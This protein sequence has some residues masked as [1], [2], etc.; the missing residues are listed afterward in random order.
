MRSPYKSIATATAV[1]LQPTQNTARQPTCMKRKGRTL[2][3]SVFS[4]SPAS[5]PAP[6]QLSN[7][8]TTDFR[9]E[10][11]MEGRWMVVAI[12]EPPYSFAIASGA[13]SLGL[14]L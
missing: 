12:F 2:T 7:Q 1:A 10:A 9:I 3:Q 4:G 14:T 13:L 5:V 11:G 6:A 8:R